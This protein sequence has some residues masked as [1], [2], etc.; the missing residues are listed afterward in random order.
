MDNKEL[1]NM[2]WNSFTKFFREV[3]GYEDW[4]DEQI[5]GS[6]NNDDIDQFIEY[7]KGSLNYEVK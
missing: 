1:D 7:I 5:G 4:N 2:I 3:K 6:M